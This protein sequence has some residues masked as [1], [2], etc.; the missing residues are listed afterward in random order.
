MSLIVSTP[1]GRTLDGLVAGAWEID[2]GHTH[3]GFTARHLMVSKV[4]GSFGEF[5]GTVTIAENV[6]DSSVSATVSMA[7]VTT[8]DAQ[9]DGHLQSGDFFDIENHPTMSFTSTGIREHGSD[10]YLDGDLTIRG[11]TK[12]VT[13]DLEFNGV[14][15][16][17]WGGQS[18]GLEAT[19]EI[20]RKDWGLE[21]N[22]ALETGGVLV[23]DKVTISLEVE[24]KAPQA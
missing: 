4:R 15:P 10:F 11:T 13:F 18:A 8:G 6:L 9:R 3:I 24:L 21:W 2:K 19:T 5:E 20:S 7:S 14:A 23:S 22:V 1:A 16:T 17:P 12:P